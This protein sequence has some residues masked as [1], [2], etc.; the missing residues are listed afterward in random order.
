MKKLLLNSVLVIALGASSFSQSLKNT[1]WY[2]Y[3]PSNVLTYYFRFDTDTIFISDNFT[4]YSPLSLYSENGSVLTFNDI[5]FV[6][7]A[8]PTTDTGFYT[9]Y[10]QNDTMFLNLISDVC[11]QRTGVLTTFHWVRAETLLQNTIWDVYDPSNIFAFRFHFETDTGFISYDLISYTPLTHFFEN[12][13]EVIFNDIP[14]IPVACPQTDTGLYTFA[15]QNDSLQFMLVTDPCTSSRILV[16]TAYHWVQNT[17]GINTQNTTQAIQLFPNPSYDGIFNLKMNETAFDK[18][19][20]STIQ[21]KLITE[22]IISERGFID[23]SINLS[24]FPAGIYL[25]T[26]H[27][28]QVNKV[29]KLVR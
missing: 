25:L 2:V 16:L 26:L 9:F 20:V 27:G 21:G 5:Q 13:N 24:D 14:G 8:C 17:T 3:N 15:I 19:S 1:T 22:T 6:P 29:L 23:R 18:I 7:Y 28:T 12:G 10:I 11:T 4:T